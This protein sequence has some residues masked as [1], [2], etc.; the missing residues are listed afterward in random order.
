MLF[1]G[2]RDQLNRMVLAA[3][4]NRA[5]VAA[6]ADH[7]V[8]KLSAKTLFSALEKFVVGDSSSHA[9]ECM[10]QSRIQSDLV[11]RRHE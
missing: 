9:I 5:L 11:I 7:A 3:D 2:N 4:L 10:G 8:V 1:R 6:P